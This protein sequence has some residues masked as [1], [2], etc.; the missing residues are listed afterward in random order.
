MNPRPSH[1]PSQ[2]RRTT[3][4]AWGLWALVVAGLLTLLLWFPLANP[5]LFRR[6]DVPNVAAFG[7][8]ALAF[9]T[10]G[11]LV[12]ARRPANPIGWILCGAAVAYVIGGVGGEYALLSV[13]TY[14]GDLPGTTAAMWASS[15]AWGLG[16]GSACTF[17]LLLFPTGALPSRRWMIFV[18]LSAVGI[19]LTVVGIALMPGPI[20]AEGHPGVLNPFGISGAQPVLRIIQDVG[21]IAFIVGAIAGIVSLF[22]RWRRARGDERQQLKWLTY[23]AG[24]LGIAVTTSLAIEAIGPGT[25][26]ATNLS[27]FIVTGSLATIPVAMGIAI[28]RHRLYDIDRI[29]NRTII[30]TLLTVFL[31]LVYSAVVIATQAVIGNDQSPLAVAISTLAAAALFRPARAR[32]QHII[33]WR[34]NRRRYDAVRTLDGFTA[35]LRDEIDLDALSAHLLAVVDETMEPARISLWLKGR[36][37]SGGQVR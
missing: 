17:P 33:D 7:A 32:I 37:L 26:R 29:I 24:L 6:T 28:L 25:E 30:Y 14:Q 15:W 31:A 21:A 11:A 19:V 4:I 13:N 27:N 8:F 12:A 36:E 5:G 35:R 23:A 1:R 2:S 10:V 22:V 16:A 34:F 9:S 20:D 18:W 3:P